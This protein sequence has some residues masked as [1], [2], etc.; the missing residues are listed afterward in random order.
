LLKEPIGYSRYMD[1]KDRAIRGKRIG[2]ESEVRGHGL[3]T[4]SVPVLSWRILR[5]PRNTWV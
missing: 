4:G 5:I 2:N 3:I 1:S